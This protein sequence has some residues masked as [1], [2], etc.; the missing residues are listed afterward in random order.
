MEICSRKF[1]CGLCVFL[2]FLECSSFPIP[3]YYPNTNV[4]RVDYVSE[5][6]NNQDSGSRD[7]VETRV[8]DEVVHVFLREDIELDRNDT[9][10]GTSSRNSLEDCSN[11]KGLCIEGIANFIAGG[12]AL[13]FLGCLACAM[14]HWEVQGER[15]ARINMAIERK[16]ITN[17]Q[18]EESKQKRQQRVNDF[19]RESQEEQKTAGGVEERRVEI[20]LEDTSTS[21]FSSGDEKK[22]LLDDTS[23]STEQLTVKAELHYPISYL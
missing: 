15:R 4:G 2:C 11:T 18:I 23:M 20:H 3:S 16:K 7:E 22:E 21:E 13:V 8:S 5:I 19:I 6:I 9:Q 1:L 10:N 14:W 12:V 17:N